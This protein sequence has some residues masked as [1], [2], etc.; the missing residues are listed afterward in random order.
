MPGDVTPW[1]PTDWE[2]HI[3]KVLKLRYAQ[4][5]GSYQHIPADIRG[6]CGLEGF[7]VDGTA[8]Q[9][10]ACQ[11]WTDFSVLLDHQKNKMTVDIGK[12]L[13]NEA[14]LL[15]I[16]GDIRIG[17][18]NF[19]LPFWNDKELLKHARKKQ[20]EVRCKSPKHVNANFRFT[21]ITGG[22]FLIEKQMLAKQGLYRFDVKDL[23]DT[24][25]TAATWMDANRG[26]ELV[27]NLTRKASV[28]AKGKSAKMRQNLLN[29]MVK[30]YTAG[31]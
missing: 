13:K 18:W 30:D 14:E 7:A 26:L 6:D 9:C 8:Y 16:L 25:A 24:L 4:P 11:N 31:S 1:D 27:T 3:Q 28:I 22:D 21:V 17:I 12:L 29:Q 10:Y 2:Q 23:P 20:M 15:T 19:V 5:V